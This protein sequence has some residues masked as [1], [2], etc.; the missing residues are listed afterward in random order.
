MSKTYLG[1]VDVFLEDILDIEKKDVE[2]GVKVSGHIPIEFFYRSQ[3]IEKTAKIVE[4]LTA[5]KEAL[6]AEIIKHKFVESLDEVF[7]PKEEPKEPLD[8]EE[9]PLK[10]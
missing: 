10:G 7:K 5:K 1:H 9:I 4:E 6:E 8:P 3:L 2:G